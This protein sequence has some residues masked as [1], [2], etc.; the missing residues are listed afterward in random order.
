MRSAVELPGRAMEK[1]FREADRFNPKGDFGPLYDR[2]DFQA[3]LKRLRD[4]PPAKKGSLGTA[5]K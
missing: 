3:L 2:D 1:G 5:G 4:L